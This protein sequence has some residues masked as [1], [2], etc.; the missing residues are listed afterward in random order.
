LP[1][2]R[3]KNCVDVIRRERAGGKREASACQ[4]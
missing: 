3:R 2:N 4:S 1:P